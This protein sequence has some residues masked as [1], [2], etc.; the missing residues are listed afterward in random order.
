M[1]N[2]LTNIFN[3]V[4]SGR[5]VQRVNYRELAQVL[6]NLKGHCHADLATPIHKKLEGAFTSIEFQN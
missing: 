3:F 1:R 4:P 6:S 5:V 2:L